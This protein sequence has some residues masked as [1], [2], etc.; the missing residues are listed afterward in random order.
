MHYRNGDRV[1]GSYLS[2]FRPVWGLRSAFGIHIA[3][4]ITLF[5]ALA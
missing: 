1:I 2:L 4:T 3:G 5:E